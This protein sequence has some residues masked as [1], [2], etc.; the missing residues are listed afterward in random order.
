MEKDLK[1][2]KK[3]N[4]YFQSSKID[5]DDIDDPGFLEDT[6]QK[7]LQKRELLVKNIEEKKNS[8]PSQMDFESNETNKQLKESST[9]F[10][11]SEKDGN[12][13]GQKAV[14]ENVSYNYRNTSNRNKVNKI[15]KNPSKNEARWSL[16]ENKILFQVLSNFDNIPEATVVRAAVLKLNPKNKK[17]IANIDTKCSNLIERAKTQNSTFVQVLSHEIKNLEENLTSHPIKTSNK[18]RKIIT[19]QVIP[20][21]NPPRK[22]SR[23]VET[24]IPQVQAIKKSIRTQNK[25]NNDDS[26]RSMIKSGFSEMNQKLSTI[27]NE[28]KT[29]QM[30]SKLNFDESETENKNDS[31]NLKNINDDDNNGSIQPIKKHVVIKRIK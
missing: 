26:L 2:S 17:T 25:S 18:K 28:I 10:S 16:N 23:K 19:S 7:L 4:E 8:L 1:L 13:E 14:S 15:N 21:R 20:K 9:H 24:K 11:D 5:S 12:N 29:L 6:K 31:K 3:D 27:R 22:S 30:N